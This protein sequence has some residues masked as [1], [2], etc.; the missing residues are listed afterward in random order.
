M[1]IHYKSMADMANSKLYVTYIHATL[2]IH[3]RRA[4]A[5][6]LTC[7]M[8]VYRYIKQKRLER[9]RFFFCIFLIDLTC[10]Y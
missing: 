8:W 3:W 9:F 2:S 1:L 4:F 7:T 5:P 10:I 6:I